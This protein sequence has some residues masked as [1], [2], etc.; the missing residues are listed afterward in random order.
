MYDA[1][2]G[3]LFEG[4]TAIK[5]INGKI[6]EINFKVRER[7]ERRNDIDFV[8]KKHREITLFFLDKEFILEDDG[9]YD[10]DNWVQK[11]KGRHV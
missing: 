9:R 8:L 10:L 3:S 11:I 7:I 5:I 2:V 6:E 1:E 4:I